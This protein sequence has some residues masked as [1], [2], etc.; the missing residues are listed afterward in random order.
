MTAISKHIWHHETDTL[1]VGSGNGALTAAIATHDLANKQILLI[2][3]SDKFGGTSALSGG[4]VWVPNNR[5]AKECGADDSYDEALK[6]L[7]QTIPTDIAQPKLIETYLQTAPEMVNFLHD[8]TRLRYISLEKYPD[9]FSDIEGAKNGHR[10]MEPEPINFSELGP[11]MDNMLEGSVMNVFY[12][13]AVTQVEAQVLMSRLKG[14]QKIMRKIMFAYY[15]DIPWLIKRKGFSRRTCGGAAGIIRLFL[16]LR[17]RKI[18]LWLNTGLEELI[19]ENGKIIGAKVIK[20]G[21][22]INIKA[23]SVILA[24]GGFEQNQQM[25]DQYLPKPTNTEWSAGCKSNTGDAIRAGQKAG[26]KT[27]LLENAWWCTTKVIPGRLPFLSII[28]KSLPGSITVNSRGLRFSNESQNYMSFLKE[29]FAQ[30]SE[31]TPCIP[32]YM[33]FDHDFRG[34]RSPWP[35]AMPDFMLKQHYESKVIAKGKTL[36]ELAENMG[37]DAQG[38]CNT[39]E[40]FNRYAEEGK[41]PDFNRGEA[42]YDRYYGDEDNK[43][44]PCLAPIKNGPFYAIRLDAGDFGTQGG[45]VINEH[46]QVC[47]EDNKPIPGLYATGNCTAAVLPSYPGPGSTLGPAMTFAYLA[48]KHIAQQKD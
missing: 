30:H 1:I 46:A 6:Y 38:L 8:N 14:W 32:A 13:F 33:I 19:T 2:E 12:K 43:P 5:Y 40:K 16:S 28:N 18:P 41:D 20:D 29:S 37:I 11:D 45:M 22:A 15:I 35:L 39:V 47:T 48:A 9:Y 23:Q 36:Q 44:N 26:A 3:K 25:R 4:G 10:S 7:Q 42:A 27:A 24:A 34:R 31:T 17:D 21:Q